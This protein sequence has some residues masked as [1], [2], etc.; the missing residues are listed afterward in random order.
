MEVS[1]YEIVPCVR[2]EFE[3]CLDLLWKVK[4]GSYGP[5]TKNE[6]N[7]DFSEFVVEM[8]LNRPA[9]KSTAADKNKP[10]QPHKDAMV[11]RVSMGCELEACIQNMPD[12]RKFLVAVTGKTRKGDVVRSSW[13]RA[14]TLSPKDRDKDRDRDGGFLDPMGQPRMNCKSCGCA[15]YVPLAW[16]LNTAEK[17]RCRRCGCNYMDHIVVDVAEILKARATKACKRFGK[18]EVVPLPSQALDW[19]DRECALWFLSGGQFH[20]RKTSGLGTDGDASEQ[21][22]YSRNGQPGRV[23]VVTPTTESRHRFHELLWR[24]FEAQTW[25]D[26]ELVV[27]ETFQSSCSHFFLDLASKDARV[28]YVKFQIPP[29]SSDWSIG[30]KRNIGAHLATGEVIANFDDDDLYAPKYLATMAGLL[31]EK[32][33]Q[34]VTLSSWFVYDEQRND[35]KFCDPIAWGLTQ[36]HD[37]ESLE[38]RSWSYGYGFSYVFKR[39]AGLDMSYKDINLGEDFAFMQDLQAQKGKRSVL[40]YHD[41]FGLCLHVQHGG[42]T[43]NSIPLREVQLEEALDLDVMELAGRMAKIKGTRPVGGLFERAVAPSLRNRRVLVHLPDRG[44]VEIECTISATVEDFVKLMEALREGASSLRVYRVPPEGFAN[45]DARDAVAADVLG[46]AFLAETPE[47]KENLK[48][49]TRAGKQWRRLLDAA[50]RPMDSRDRLGLRTTELWL[51]PPEESTPAV[52]ESLEEPDTE[53]F[54]MV[55]ATCQR[56]N[57]KEFFSAI[58]ACSIYL[59]VGATVGHLRQILG[60]HLP[61]TAKVLEEKGKDA[62]EALKDSDLVPEKVKFTDF[63]GKHRFYTRFSYGQCRKA[64]RHMATFFARPENQRRLDEI[65]QR[66]HAKGKDA[67]S[68]NLEFHADLVKVLMH[69]TYPEIWRLVGVPDDLAH[70]SQIVPSLGSTVGDSVELSELWLRAEVMMRNRVGMHAAFFACVRVRAAKGLPPLDESSK[71]EW[72]TVPVASF[73]QS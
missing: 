14:E 48:P 55:H 18:K 43:S 21:H 7:S 70:P 61:A 31:D 2:Q 49:E 8:V 23:S 32:K 51:L 15:G 33:A 41:D 57:A 4:R 16:G 47:A 37:E 39:T 40:L 67:H 19:D 20:P 52:H 63:K 36:G 27:V 6:A 1:E 11:K 24:C 69:E 56:T 65:E 13:I 62:P 5:L 9:A 53:Q 3:E 72:L 10:L 42:N 54:F 34:A 12:G 68:R 26:K 59:Q 73:R 29:G 46:I 58:N 44:A 66:A 22:R 30:L 17:M 38:V 45:K 35:W 25:P 28:K 71:P 60:D 64:L 50:M